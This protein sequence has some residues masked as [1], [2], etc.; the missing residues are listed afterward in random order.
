MIQWTVLK[1][2][3]IFLLICGAYAAGN[4]HATQWALK[5]EQA[6]AE[7]KV[8][9]AVSAQKKADNVFL[10][11]YAATE[12][13]KMKLTEN[14]DAVQKAVQKY[15]LLPRPRAKPTEGKTSSAAC[16][17]ALSN[18][19]VLLHDYAADGSSPPDSPPGDV[20]AP[21]EVGEAE[22]AGVIGRN[23]H[24]CLADKLTLQEWQD[25]YK[26]LDSGPRHAP[27]P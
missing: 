13:K 25:W 17:P 21:S 11:I 1:Y 4:I 6:L 26:S 24:S 22:A 16:S 12:P 19:F 10:K 14:S 5:Q 20:G 27:S 23:Y 8:A 15:I 9:K 7:K 2:C 18:G 3:A